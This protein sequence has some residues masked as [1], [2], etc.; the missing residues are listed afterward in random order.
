MSHTVQKVAE[1]IRLCRRTLN[2][3]HFIFSRKR[4]IVNLNNI[5]QFPCNRSK[6]MRVKENTNRQTNK[7]NLNHKQFK[8]LL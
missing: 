8:N 1:S 4:P 5:H 2:A 7:T 6:F 3:I